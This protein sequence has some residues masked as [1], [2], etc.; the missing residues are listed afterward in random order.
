MQGF[1]DG[2]MEEGLGGREGGREGRVCRDARL[3]LSALQRG[4]E[5]KEGW[6]GGVKSCRE[7]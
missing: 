5:K 1:K 6:R 2:G 7:G 3:H 4:E